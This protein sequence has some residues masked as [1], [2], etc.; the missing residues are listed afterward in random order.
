MEHRECLRLVRGQLVQCGMEIKT[1]VIVFFLNSSTL[2]PLKAANKPVLNMVHRINFHPQFLI[3]ESIN[4]EIK[5]LHF[6]FVSPP[7]W[8]AALVTHPLIDN[9]ARCL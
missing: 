5:L 1:Q 6:L 7:K 3:S 8:G 2:P 4:M 9:P